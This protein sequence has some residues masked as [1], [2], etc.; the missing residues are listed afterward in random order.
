MI[1]ACFFSLA[2][3][4]ATTTRPTTT[5]RRLLNIF[6][7]SSFSIRT[8]QER[9]TVTES[10]RDDAHREL[11]STKQAAA[12]AA[13]AAAV[14]LE[15]ARNKAE[16]AS[17]SAAQALADAEAADKERAIERDEAVA[18]AAAREDE[19]NAA[20]GELRAE[21][22]LLKDE[23][24]SRDIEFEAATGRIMDDF[25]SVYRGKLARAESSIKQKLQA[26]SDAARGIAVEVSDQQ[27]NRCGT[28]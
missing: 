14:E 25:E 17:A 19:F 3:A 9:V 13:A 23:L 24:M 20:E 5:K 26:S 21:V 16:V 4:T 2:F 15:A 8:S 12:M 27:K 10:A 28:R 6:V 7:P 18:R 22:E 1:I 11:T